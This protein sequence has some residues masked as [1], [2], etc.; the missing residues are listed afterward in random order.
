ML[1]IVEIFAILILHW[2]FD[3]VLQTSWQA[4]NKS[5]NNQA[6]FEHVLTYSL[7]W[8][9]CGV[10]YLNSNI[11]LPLDQ[12]KAL[13]TNIMLFTVITFVCHFITDYL[14]SRLNTYLWNKKDVHNFFVSI[15]HDQLWYY[16][17]LFIT[18]YLLK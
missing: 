11:H 6:L 3:F 5:K 13:A 7:A 18:Y 17:Q 10:I 16:F 4:Q 14:T 12:Y 8:F 9:L 1:S 2:I 15:G